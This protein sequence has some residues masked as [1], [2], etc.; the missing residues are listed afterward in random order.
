[1]PIVV[2][3]VVGAAAV[4][5]AAGAVV[6]YKR[7]KPNE[8]EENIVELKGRSGSVDMSPKPI[9]ATKSYTSESDM[10]RWEIPYESIK[11]GA[12][13]GR[14]AYGSVFLATWRN[15][16]C[17]VKQLHIDNNN[18]S[19]V[20]E[21]LK[22]AQTVQR[23]RPHK[24]VCGIFGVCTNPQYPIC[25][26]MEYVKDGSLKDLVYEEPKVELTSSLILALAKDIASGMAHLHMENVLHCDLACRNLLVQKQSGT[27]LIKISDFGLAR[28]SESGLYD[29]NQEA[30]FPIRW[31]APEVLTARKLSRAADVWSFGVVLW[32]MLEGK[33]PFWEM[34]NSEVMLHVCTK[35][36]FLNPPTKRFEYPEELNAMM[37]ACFQFKPEARPSFEDLFIQLED[38][39]KQL[40]QKSFQ[41]EQPQPVTR[42]LS[43]G[44]RQYEEFENTSIPPV[45]YGNEQG[46]DE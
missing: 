22:E 34:S 24:N 20:R 2:G 42:Q 45:L 15:S 41:E 46:S 17:V 9:Y 7:R 36:Q 38:I 13:I 28:T 4:C 3:V 39:E 11:Q 30:K 43:T 27:Y 6:K 35:K 25:I 31:S 40:K 19:A 1:V 8:D 10:T 32:E 37:L 21:F 12:E 29:A 16:E 14:G 33:M 23:L 18:P 44:G 26:V 5:F